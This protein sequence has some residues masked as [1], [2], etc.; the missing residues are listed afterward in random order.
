M[1]P[2]AM[3]TESELN[4]RIKRRINKVPNAHNAISTQ[5]TT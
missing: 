3:H 4:F 5:N 1:H 2:I